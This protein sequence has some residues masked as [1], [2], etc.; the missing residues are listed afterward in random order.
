MQA[1]ER[2]ARARCCVWSDELT[3]PSF[4]GRRGGERERLSDRPLKRLPAQFEEPKGT[5]GAEQPECNQEPSGSPG[6]GGVNGRRRDGTRVLKARPVHAGDSGAAARILRRAD[7]LTVHDGRVQHQG[8]TA[9]LP[10]LRVETRRKLV[11][12]QLLLFTGFLAAAAIDNAY[13]VVADHARAGNP[14]ALWRPMVWE[15][16][17]ALLIGML[18][19]AIGWWVARFPFVRGRV[20]VSLA[21]H[22]VATVPFSLM[23]TA[24]MVWVRELAYRSIGA[25]Y[26]FGPFWANW[27]YE[28]RKDWLSYFL[29]LGILLAVRTYGLWLDARDRERPPAA[30]ALP[31]GRLLV[32]K[33]NREF[34]LDVDGI[35]R[36]EAD[37][38]YVTVHSGG[39]SYRV[40]ESLEGLATRLGA[41]RFARVHR[42]HVVNI[43]RIR[44][45]QPWENGD[46]RILLKD[47]S[48]LNFSRRYRSRLT[49]LIR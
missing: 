3:I 11:A 10:E 39:E 2:E 43:D 34:I 4:D 36:I 24:G 31:L 21:A 17:S 37:G 27:L 19:P 8:M 7:V 18:V 15:C 23:H 12:G 13:T 6:D 16:S 22:L 45:I 20:A 28:Y 44:E 49:H 40:R 35:D 48:F 47:G 32:R 1:H 42:A 26:D 41:E 9:P 5:G 46:Y 33:R 30:A 38:N 14:I 29:I 25:H